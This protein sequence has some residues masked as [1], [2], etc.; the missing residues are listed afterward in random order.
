[1]KT[2]VKIALEKSLFEFK[3]FDFFLIYFDK[4]IILELIDFL[5]IFFTVFPI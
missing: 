5:I 4:A 2:T 3:I 1:M